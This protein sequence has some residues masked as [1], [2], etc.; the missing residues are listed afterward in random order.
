[1]KLNTVEYA[2]NGPIA[3]VTLNRPEKLNAMNAEMHE[4][5]GQVWS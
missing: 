5:L 1:M 4:E 2:K 3:Y